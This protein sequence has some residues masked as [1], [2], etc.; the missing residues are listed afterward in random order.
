MLNNGKLWGL[1]VA[2]HC[3]DV[4]KWEDSDITSMRLYSQGLSAAPS[5]QSEVLDFD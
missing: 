3:Q 4:K 1:L 2:H 5:I